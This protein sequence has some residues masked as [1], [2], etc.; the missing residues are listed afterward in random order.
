M[1]RRIRPDWSKEDIILQRF[2]VPD[3]INRSILYGGYTTSK[4][5]MVLIKV[6]DPDDVHQK[7]L[8]RENSGD[9]CKIE[10]FYFCLRP[11]AGG[12]SNYLSCCSGH[13]VNLLLGC[14][15]GLN[16]AADLRPVL[17]LFMFQFVFCVS[18]TDYNECECSF[19]ANVGEKRKCSS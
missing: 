19:N 10:I 12:P 13:V 8:V 2:T 9:V 7:R 3:P 5:E 11:K 17:A 6:Y 15:S 1:V 16:L 14:T 18:A 4:S